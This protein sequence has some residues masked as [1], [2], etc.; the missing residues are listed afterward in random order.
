MNEASFKEYI[1]DP[2][3]KIPGTNFG[4]LAGITLVIMIVTGI[5]LAMH[6]TPTVDGA[7]NSVEHTAER[8]RGLN[9]DAVERHAEVGARKP[10][11]V[12]IT[13]NDRRLAANCLVDLLPID[14]LGI[15]WRWSP[16]AAPM[17]FSPTS[18]RA[19][20]SNTDGSSP[21]KC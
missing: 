15:G 12:D 14:V 13:G 1:K 21:A 16:L 8:E 10:V 4:S 7:F 3:A 5:V 19:R 17:L 11:T 20:W 18:P 2:K 9:R 6:Y